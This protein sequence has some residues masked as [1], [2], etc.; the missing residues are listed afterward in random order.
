VHSRATRAGVT[1][2]LRMWTDAF[3]LHHDAFPVMPTS[4]NLGRR[5]E[6]SSLTRILYRIYDNGT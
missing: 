6:Y 4:P 1:V 2:D 5:K 3:R